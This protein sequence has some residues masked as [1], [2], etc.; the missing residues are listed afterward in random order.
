[1]SLLHCPIKTDT[2]W[3]RP[4]EFLLLAPLSIVFSG[5]CDAIS[6]TVVS[7]GHFYFAMY[8]IAIGI[9]INGTTEKET[10]REREVFVNTE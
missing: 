1:M 6:A 3:V 8:T 2:R 7:R 4:L 10:E 9:S 5:C